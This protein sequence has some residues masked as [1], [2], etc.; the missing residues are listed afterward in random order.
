LKGF[1]QNRQLGLVE[2]QRDAAHLLS[3]GVIGVLATATGTKG[4]QLTQKVGCSLPGQRRCARGLIA[5]QAFTMTGLAQTGLRMSRF[6]VGTGVQSPPPGRCIGHE[7][8][9]PGDGVSLHSRRHGHHF[10]SDFVLPVYTTPALTE[11]FKLP[12]YIPIRQD[13][14][15]GA[16]YGV[17]TVQ[18]RA[19]ANQA[20]TKVLSSLSRRHSAYGD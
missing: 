18:V 13:A 9:S 7:S 11:S 14:Q 10:L 15:V 8:R 3:I 2:A 12:S 16:T 17:I 4:S 6:I 20:I 1:Y 19:M 5:L